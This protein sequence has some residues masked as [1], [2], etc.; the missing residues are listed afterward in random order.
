MNATKNGDSLGDR[1]KG[2][3]ACFDNKLPQRCPMVL[4]V[5]GKTFHTLTKK[6]KC[7]RPYDRDLQMS[8][9]ATMMELC[10]FISGSVIGYTQ[11]D[12]ISIVVR[13]DM[14][15][16]TQPFLDK[17]IQKLCSIVASKAT[18]AFNEDY[19]IYHAENFRSK[20][21]VSADLVYYPPAMFDCR[22]FVMPEYEVQNYL[23][24]RQQDATRNSIQMLGQSLYSHK[25]L[26]GKNCSDLQEMCFQ[27]GHNW[28]KLEVWQKRGACAVRKL[29]NKQ[30]DGVSF[31]R[32]VWVVDESIPVFTK[33]KEYVYN[34]I[35]LEKEE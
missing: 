24:W 19:R 3:E 15:I 11:S 31:T 20:D 4:R 29:E 13:D 25:E 17:R 28:D 10:K 5:D 34:N 14:S 8:M 26:H 32:N 22:V 21:S 9:R 33:D 30:R 12:E 1:M 16:A 23:V 35:K 7:M 18:A 2:Y 6:W 27:K